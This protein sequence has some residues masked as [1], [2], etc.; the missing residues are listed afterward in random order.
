MAANPYASPDEA[1]AAFYKAFES[2]DLEAMM[3]VWAAD[4]AIVC[5]HPLGPRLEGPQQVAESW[6][7]IFEGGSG[8]RFRITDARHLLGSDLVVHLVRENIAVLADHG[9]EST[10]LAT[11]V[12]RRNADGWRMVLHHASPGPGAPGLGDQGEGVPTMH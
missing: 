8:L 1:E 11:N 12:Y 5:V 9:R 6:R 2:S 3:A 7:R 4:E 10:V